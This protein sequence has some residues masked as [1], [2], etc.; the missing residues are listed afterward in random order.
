MPRAS[1][2]DL[3]A[4]AESARAGIGAFNVIQLEHAEAIVAGAEQAGRPVILQISEN[5]VAYHG[6]LAPLAR[7]CLS[8]ADQTAAEVVVHLDHMTRS[9][10]LREASELGVMSL[11]FDAS[12]LSYAEN[13][14]LTRAVVEDAHA[15]GAWVEA[16]LG[17]VGGKEGVHAP[18]VRTRPDEAASYVADTGVDALAVAVGSSHAMLTR[19]AELDERLI[20]EIAGAV[21]VPLVLHGSSGVPDDGLCRAVAHGIR[22]VNIATQL[23]KVMAVAVRRALDAD[24]ALVDPR[25]Y[26]GPGRE[27]VTIEVTRL[28]TLLAPAPY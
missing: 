16:E 7:A 15:A 14:A 3:A 9:N 24:A 10:A 17:E 25:R 23:N 20:A 1:M 12:E 21:P 13:V 6:S 26:L 4:R 11:M 8:I 27:A 5:T 18:G 28:L 2:P 19:E 22:K